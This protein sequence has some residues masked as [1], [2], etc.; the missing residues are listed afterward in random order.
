MAYAGEKLRE[1]GRGAAGLGDDFAAALD[2]AA[3]KTGLFVAFDRAVAHF[4]D[5]LVTTVAPGSLA[6][7]IRFAIGAGGRVCD[8]FLIAGPW[9]EQLFGFATQPVFEEVAE[10]AAH[11]RMPEEARPYRRFRQRLAEG[12]PVVRNGVRLG[13]AELI[14]AYFDYVARLVRSI[15]ERGVVPRGGIDLGRIA[16]LETGPVRPLAGEIFERDIGVGLGADGEL[17]RVCSGAH[18]MATAI[19]LGLA[20]VPVELRLIHVEFLAKVMAQSGCDPLDAV[21]RCVRFVAETYET[22]A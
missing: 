21:P 7:Q 19:V 3:G 9:R 10:I 5:A 4:G 12:N 18:R 17:F 14:D 22:Q 20:A 16:E 15:R 6:H 11:G 2:A 1:A 8:R 13:S